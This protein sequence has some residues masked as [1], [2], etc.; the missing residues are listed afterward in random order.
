MDTSNLF[1]PLDYKC[2]ITR[3]LLD[4][5]KSVPDEDW[6]V[7]RGFIVTFIPDEIIDLD[8]CLRAEA[9]AA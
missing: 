6:E 5:A 2:P 9:A 8:P 1:I 7:Q 4:F 3:V